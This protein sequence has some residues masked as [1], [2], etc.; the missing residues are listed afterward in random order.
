MGVRR[1]LDWLATTWPDNKHSETCVRPLVDSKRHR[2]EPPK[3]QYVRQALVMNSEQRRPIRTS[4]LV[5]VIG[6][7]S[8]AAQ[9]QTDALRYGSITAT[10]YPV[11]ASADAI[12]GPDVEDRDGDGDRSE[13]VAYPFGHVV[14]PAG[15]LSGRVPAPNTASPQPTYQAGDAVAIETGGASQRI[16]VDASASGANDGTSWEDAYTDLQDFLQGVDAQ[17]CCA[18]GGCEVWVAAGTY[19]PDR[20]TEVRST[21]F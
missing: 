18:T 3:V 15:G 5:M 13:L 21:T 19:T 4:V 8:V 11:N 1:A 7:F 14:R 17:L 20:G 6:L 10:E 12:M 2:K 9:A 16:Y